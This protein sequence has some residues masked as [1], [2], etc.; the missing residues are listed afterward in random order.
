M[1]IPPEEAKGKILSKIEKDYRIVEQF[2]ITYSHYDESTRSWSMKG[3]FS[4]HV[5]E[6]SIKKNFDCNVRDNGRIKCDITQAFF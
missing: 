4:T 2:K 5:T 1:S 3:S 6:E